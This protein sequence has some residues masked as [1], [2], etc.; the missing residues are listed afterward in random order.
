[1][2]GL[3]QE[4][5]ATVP[6]MIELVEAVL[7]AARLRK[8]IRHGKGIAARLFPGLWQE[9]RTDWARLDQLKEW[10]LELK[11]SIEHGHLTVDLMDYLASHPDERRIEFSRLEEALS[12]HRKH[13]DALIETLEFDASRR[14]EDKAILLARDFKEQAMIISLWAE[15]L[16]LLSAMV[17]FNHLASQLEEEHLFGV[18]EL[19]K[20]WAKAP[21]HLLPHFRRT[22]LERLL[23]HA[24][25]HRAPLAQFDGLSHEEAI[26]RFRKLDSLLIEHTRIQLAE[27]HW[28]ALPRHEASGQLGILRRE[29]EKKARHLPIRQLI[30]KAGHAIRAIKPVFMMSPLSIATFLASDTLHFDLVVFD[31]ASQVKPVDAFGAIL[32]GKQTVVVGDKK[33]MPPTDFFESL[34]RVSEEETATSDIESILGL[35]EAKG[36][37]SRMLRWHYRSRHQSL[38][39]VSNQEFYDDRLVIFPSPERAREKVGLIY[40]HLPTTHYLPGANPTN[41]GEAQAV[42]EAVMEHARTCPH[43]TLGVAAFSV[44]QMIEI[45]DKVEQLRREDP[46][47]EAFFAAHPHEPFFIKNL[48]TIQGDERDV[49][50]ISIGYGRTSEGKVAMNF[51]P[52]NRDGGGRRLNVLI[53]RARLRC[54]VFTNMTPDDIDLHRSN[55]DGVKALKRFLDYAASG[56]KE[57]GKNPLGTSSLGAKVKAALE[58]NGYRVETNV[59]VAGFFLDL[60]VVDPI[61]SDRYRLGIQCDGATYFGAKTARDRD[62]LRVQVLEGLGWRL[63]RVWSTDWY[64]HPERELERLIEALEEENIERSENPELPDDSW[65]IERTDEAP[66]EETGVPEY[67]LADLGVLLADLPSLPLNVLA[68]FIVQVVTEESPV[69]RDEVEK[70]IAAAAGGK[71]VGQRL[72]AALEAARKH[73]VKTGAIHEKEGFLWREGMETPPLRDRRKLPSAMRKLELVSPEE[74]ALAIERVVEQSYGIER[75]KLPQA[76]LK[77]LGFSRISEDGLRTIERLIEGLFEA[78]RIEERG[79][80]VR[81]VESVENSE[82]SENSEQP[83]S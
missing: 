1:M 2:I 43:L 67:R 14:F 48:E 8:K 30:G 60:A 23:E 50:F 58:A 37:P 63:H 45:Q 80:F 11:K 73:A 22:Y 41:P 46:S 66:E 74:W 36:A 56:I 39:A 65:E 10:I 83:V 79:G 21:L 38:I 61:D 55:R 40:R 57:Q 28:Q 19:A 68:A 62:R 31:E 64:Q 24:F 78:G 12:A 72:Q 82:N 13:L 33:Q 53:T 70:R 26:Q 44:A 3:C 47:T 35:F 9:E 54:E 49:V 52:L 25:R 20:G 5:P 7:E 17:R 75:E 27:M 42:A 4:A 18:I 51:G 15:S 29:F 69:H 76:A 6:E 32:R 71:R 77:L 16:P 34:N 59:G 81:L